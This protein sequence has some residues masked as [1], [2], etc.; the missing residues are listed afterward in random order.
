MKREEFWAVENVETFRGHDVVNGE[1]D[2]S[3]DAYGDRIDEIYP[4]V[5]VAGIHFNPSRI[6]QELDPVAWRC[7]KGDWESELTAS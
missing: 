1:V 4:T 3:D 6:I 2:V 5:E 7:G